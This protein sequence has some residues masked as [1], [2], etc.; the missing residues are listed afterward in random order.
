MLHRLTLPLSFELI[1]VV[2]K[3]MYPIRKTRD[4]GGVGNPW[5]LTGSNASPRSAPPGDSPTLPCA[6]GPPHLGTHSLHNG[7]QVCPQV[8]DSPAHTKYLAVRGGP[9]RPYGAFHM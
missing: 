7:P 8:G 9:K 4:G 5:G 2:K 6:P 1:F 3:V